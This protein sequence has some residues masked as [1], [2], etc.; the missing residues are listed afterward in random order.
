MKLPKLLKLASD[1]LSDRSLESLKRRAQLKEIQ[2]KLKKKTKRL[3]EKYEHEQDEV[4]RKEIK[5]KI[6]VASAQRKKVI[7]ELKKIDLKN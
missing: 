7:K 3:K 6:A 2:R 4:A 1:I 5:Q